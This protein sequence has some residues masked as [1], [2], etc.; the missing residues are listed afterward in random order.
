MDRSRADDLGS[1]GAATENSLLA[2]NRRLRGQIEQ[3][4][5]Q[6]RNNELILR[7]HHQL[8][9]KLIAANGIVSLLETIFGDLKTSAALDQLTLLILDTE[10]ELRRV[11]TNLDIPAAAFP[12]LLLHQTPAQL[13]SGLLTMSRPALAL[14]DDARHGILFS[15]ESE[16][17]AS[18]A[19]LPLV[20][21][22]KLVGFLNFGS[23]DP[24]RFTPQVATDFIAEQASIITICLENVVNNERLKHIGLT[25]P[26]TGVNNR[27]YIEMRL[28]EEI[29]RAQRQRYDLSCMYI[30]LDH[31]KQINDQLGHREGDE[32]LCEAAARI[33]AELRLSDS[34]G[35]FGGEE[36]VV[37][38]IDTNAEGA[39]HVAERI[40]ASIANRPFMLSGG[41][42]CRATV[43]IGVA[44]LPPTS[45]TQPI[46]ILA[47]EFVGRADAALY[48][49]KNGGRNRVKAVD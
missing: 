1:V 39:R 23:L 14:Y 21:R 4:L 48:Q 20:R 32:V 36:F 37:L 28:Q 2:E 7:R 43:S 41:R 9:L 25:D 46:D 34:L 38:L 27:R 17:P 33:K 15:G 26:L 30:D 10:H 45:I 11:M 42:S 22:Q 44:S 16:P 29:K 47:R 12:Q 13:G 31:F 18:V 5:E 6:A 19:I 24:S 3:F 35:R 40:R 49:A 8:N